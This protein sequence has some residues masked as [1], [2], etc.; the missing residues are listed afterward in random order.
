MNGLAFSREEI[1]RLVRLVLADLG[2]A[3][4]AGAVSVPKGAPSPAPASDVTELRLSSRVITLEQISGAS[5]CRRVVV[6]PGAVVTPAVKDE[7]RKGGIE[8]VFDTA[9]AGTA[10]PGAPSA[11][12]RFTLS[13]SNAAPVAASPRAPSAEPAVSLS[14]AF[15]DIAPET[16]PARFLEELGRTAPVEV[17]QNKCVIQAAAFLAER[18]AREKSKGVLLTRYTAAA[19]AVCN[20]KGAI[21]ALVG[22]QADRLGADAASI[23]ANLLI[24][25]PGQGLFQVRRMIGRFIDLGAT[26]CPKS[27]LKGLMT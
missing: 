25:D 19:S 20:R 16:L 21:R 12:A 26:S 10:L 27:L 3:G 24:V 14:V 1:A 8:L 6:A 22:T 11:P 4:G 2:Q 23:G 15:H 5:A 13:A 18:L 9:A 7:L 17:Y